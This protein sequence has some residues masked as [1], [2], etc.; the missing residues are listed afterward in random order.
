ML[1][2]LSVYFPYCLIMSFDLKD[3]DV[4]LY[5]R[6]LNMFLGVWFW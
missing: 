2:N 4:L 6:E 5:T 3:M 1:G